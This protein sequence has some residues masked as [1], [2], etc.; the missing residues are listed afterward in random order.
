MFKHD[1]DLRLGLCSGLVY[2]RAA[3][4]RSGSDEQAVM[5]WNSSK[6]E[7]LKSLEGHRCVQVTKFCETLR[8]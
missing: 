3:L 5:I 2:R 1:S 8:V 7:C 6:G 4:Q